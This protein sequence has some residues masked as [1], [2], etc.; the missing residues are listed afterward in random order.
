MSAWLSFCIVFQDLSDKLKLFCLVLPTQESHSS[1]MEL[2]IVACY[3][4]K[5]HCAK[6]TANTV[7]THLQ[8]AV[9]HCIP[10]H[11]QPEQPPYSIKYLPA[12]VAISKSLCSSCRMSDRAGI[13]CLAVRPSAMSSKEA[14]VTPS[15]HVST[16]SLLTGVL[17]T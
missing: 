12:L 13:C 14:V 7:Y 3:H 9:C 16:A 8:Q 10:T 6:N 5:Y 4:I 15:S 11:S 17:T 2:T 1:C